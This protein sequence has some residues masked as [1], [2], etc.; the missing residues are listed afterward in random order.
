[1]YVMIRK[2]FF[3]CAHDTDE[4]GYTGEQEKWTED[5][6]A[7]IRCAGVP[8]GGLVPVNPIYSLP[9]NKNQKKHVLCATEPA[10]PRLPTIPRHLTS[11]LSQ[12]PFEPFN[13]T[14]SGLPSLADFLN[15]SLMVPAV[16]ARLK[17]LDLATHAEFI[18]KL[19]DKDFPAKSVRSSH[20]R[21]P[22]AR[23]MRA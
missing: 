5:G 4:R 21:A 1:M 13:D 22:P 7:W 3:H 11:P 19:K 16:G 10:S 18:A 20:P 23:A 14:G 6:E 15:K 2:C 12:D 9:P 17:K 8:L